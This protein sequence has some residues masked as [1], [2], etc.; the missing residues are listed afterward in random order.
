MMTSGTD[1]ISFKIRPDKVLQTDEVVIAVEKK[2]K[3][4][5]KI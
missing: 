4:N 5:K 3:Q 2:V 1:L